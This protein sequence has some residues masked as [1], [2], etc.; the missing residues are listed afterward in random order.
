M[1]T[2]MDY[3]LAVYIR[4]WN[5]RTAISNQ[6]L[7]AEREMSEVGEK[8]NLPKSFLVRYNSVFMSELQAIY[9]VRVFL[10]VQKWDF[11]EIAKRHFTWVEKRRL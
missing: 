5:R 2:K 1:H 11:Y 9:P 7:Q 8:E 6:S 3:N 10:F 4:D